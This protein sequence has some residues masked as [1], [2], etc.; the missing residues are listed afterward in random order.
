M[1]Q[2]DL[3]SDDEG[4]DTS[5]LSANEDEKDEEDELD[6]AA[7]DGGT[8]KKKIYGKTMCKKLHATYFNDRREVEFFGEQPIGPTKEV[9]SNLNQILG[10]TVRNPR[11]VTLLYTSWHGVPKNLKE[12]MW[13]Y[14]NQKFI[15]PITSK[16]WVMKGF[17]RAWKKYKG[18]IK[19]EHFLKYNTKKEMI[20][21]RPLEIL[22]VQFCKLIRYWSLPTVK[23]VST[24]NAENRSKQTCPHPMGSTNFGIVRKQLVI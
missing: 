1:E 11:F 3:S 24:K 22:E 20:K 17:C 13:E 6:D 19:K 14:A 12:D 5:E 21:N 8:I 16:P 2:N 7:N 4:E 15:L 23:D 18:E 10:T 9:V